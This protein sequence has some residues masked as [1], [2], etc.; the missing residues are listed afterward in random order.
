MTGRW[1]KL[2]DRQRTRSLVLTACFTAL[3]GAG[4]A[5]A[6]QDWIVLDVRG[7]ALKSGERVAPGTALRL[8]EGARL[9]LIARTGRS[10]TLRGLFDG[11][12]PRIEGD[13][14]DP[15]RAL[16][17]L[18]AA[19]DERVRTI[20]VVRSG[21]GSARL[22]DPWLID[23]SRAGPRCLQDGRPSFF[24]RP[25]G[26]GPTTLTVWPTDRS[27]RVDFGWPA[28]QDRVPIPPEVRPT[29]GQTLVA[30]YGDREHAI[31]FTVIAPSVTEPVLIAAWMIE[32]GCIQQ[33]DAL[34]DAWIRQTSPG[35]A[36]ADRR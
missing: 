16:S 24:W 10:L 14:D 22:P 1:R 9:T 18:I 5:R 27:W 25:P 8:P 33:A 20:G 26:T 7:A 34:L 13:P 15:R 31:G 3:L 12:I 35:L 28:D 29:E 19:R 4:G 17:A 23:I 6:S 11:A 21:D 36:T 2:V 30:E 32:K